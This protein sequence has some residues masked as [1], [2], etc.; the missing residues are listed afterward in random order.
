[1][2]TKYPSHASK[3][4]KEL[5]LKKA[6]YIIGVGGDGTLH[7]IINGLFNNKKSLHPSLTLGYI[8]SG[9]GQ[10]FSRNFSYPNNLTQILDVLKNK[11]T[12]SCDIAYIEVHNSSNKKKEYYFINCCSVGLGAYAAKIANAKNKILGARLSYLRSI[13]QAIFVCKPTK[14]A[15]VRNKSQTPLIKNINNISIANGCYVGGG[16]YIAPHAKVSDGFF[17]MITFEDM[18]KL[19]L[20]RHLPR[21]YSG[22]HLELDKVSEEKSQSLTI[23]PQSNETVFVEADGEYIGKLPIKVEVLKKAVLFVRP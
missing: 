6:D 23:V 10:D 9:T 22:K 5:A 12:L 21:A 20:L 3:L 18:N 14:V 16:L 1:M 17:D 7:E 8:P 13:L 11:K 19:E 15:I 2:F 4:A